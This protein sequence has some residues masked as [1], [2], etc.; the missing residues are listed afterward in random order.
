MEPP[1]NPVLHR[2][3]EEVQ[4][5]LVEAPRAEE[6]VQPAGTRRVFGAHPLEHQG[7]FAQARAR[8]RRETAIRHA[9][10]LALVA[11]SSYLI[12]SIR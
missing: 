7:H 5:M 9:Q 1:K 10:G 11:A 6:R 2:R 4:D 12:A 3:R 8:H